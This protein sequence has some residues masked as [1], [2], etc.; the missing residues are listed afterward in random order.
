MKNFQSTVFLVLPLFFLILFSSC[1]SPKK[2]VIQQSLEAPRQ[3]FSQGYLQKAID[4]YTAALQKYPDVTIVIKDYI[5]TLE[6]IKTSADNAYEA[7]NYVSAE[8]RYSILLN[9]FSRFKTFENSLSFTSKHLSRRIKECFMARSKIQAHNA[10]KSGD[11]TKALEIHK[12]AIQA[13]PEDPPLKES[14]IETI[15]EIHGEGEKALE[16]EDY[17]QTGKRYALL[18]KEHH[19][20]K[21]M[22][23]PLP[24]SKNTL[25]EG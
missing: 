15:N 23:A 20:L 19:W 14:L 24:F 16:R 21:N 18:L 9:N 13:F 1:V 7:K 10:I 12:L 25:E 17:V 22:D 5:Q 2:D 3:Q 6:E 11:Y 8:Q 4:G